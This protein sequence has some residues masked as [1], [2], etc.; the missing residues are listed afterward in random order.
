MWWAQET[1]AH[2]LNKIKYAT[3]VY[4]VSIQFTLMLKTNC[5]S[6]EYRKKKQK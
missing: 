2:W 6:P 1:I 3:T 4:G 5:T